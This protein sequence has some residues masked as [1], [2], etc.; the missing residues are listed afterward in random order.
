MADDELL[1]KGREIQMAMWPHMK[2]GGGQFSA[3]KLAP[4][5]YHYM[6]ETTFDII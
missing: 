4:N 5:F 1:E 6:T 2:S 3:A